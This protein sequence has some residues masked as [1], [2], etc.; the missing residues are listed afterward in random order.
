MHKGEQTPADDAPKLFFE[1]MGAA[2]AIAQ[3][4]LTYAH[5]KY[6]LERYEQL[7]GII[8]QLL[9]NFLAVPAASTLE[10]LANDSGYA[11][12]KLDVRALLLRGTSVLLV[13][14]KMDGLWSLPGG[15]ADV[16]SSPRESV[17]REVLDETGL[18]V[19]ASRMLALYDKQKRDYP[20]QLPHAYKCF[21]L[22]QES[23]GQLTQGTLETAKAE[24]FEHDAIPSLSRHR[25]TESQLAH[26]LKLAINPAAPTEFD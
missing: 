14:E 18:I 1:A 9:G 7:R 13:Q 5:D 11:T 25:I 3:N 17:E 23:G 26:L 10:W 15:W 19:H 22:C 21:F 12:P 2:A 4:G 16:N 20:P 6:D 24:F 8:A